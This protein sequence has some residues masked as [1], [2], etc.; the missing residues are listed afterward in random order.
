MNKNKVKVIILAIIMV[1][2]ILLVPINRE[3]YSYE[4]SQPMITSLKNDAKHAVIIG[5]DDGFETDVIMSRIEDVYNI[6]HTVFVVTSRISEQRELMLLDMLFR[7]HDIQSHGWKHDALGRIDNI[8]HITKIFQ[9]SISDIETMFGYTPII[10]A[11]PF[12]SYSELST[13]IV[14]DYFDVGRTVEYENRNRLGLMN[15]SWLTMPHSLSHSHGICDSMVNKIFNTFQNMTI[16]HDNNN[17]FKLYGHTLSGFLSRH[18]FDDVVNQLHRIQHHYPDTWF[19]TWGELFSY[20]IVHSNSH[21]DSF[22]YDEMNIK[23]NI[24]TTVDTTSYPIPITIK[25][26]IPTSWTPTII[27]DGIKTEYSI[28]ED[29]RRRYIM[30]NAVPDSTVTITI[31]DVIFNGSNVAD[32]HIKHLG[33]GTVITIDIES[34]ITV[35]RLQVIVNNQI[36]TNVMSPVFWNNNTFGLVIYDHIVDPNIQIS[37]L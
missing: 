10:F 29:E 32:I 37:F 27:V 9:K 22:V 21:I 20:Q 31:G 18:L 5:Y 28:V 34:D 23:F 14:K 35:K 19:T 8:T 36:F 25:T 16:L 26:E 7:G 1:I 17:V 13:S 3:S 24:N 12:G 30:F 6:H 4:L 33:N 15:H 2:A 11:Y